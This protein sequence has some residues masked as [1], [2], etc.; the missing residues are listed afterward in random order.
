MPY[1]NFR[2]WI[3]NLKISEETNQVFFMNFK[4]SKNNQ[5]NKLYVNKKFIRNP[6]KLTGKYTHRNPKWKRN[7]PYFPHICPPPLTSENMRR[8]FNLSVS[9]IYYNLVFISLFE[10]K[11]KN[12]HLTASYRILFHI[13]CRNF[14]KW[15]RVCQKK[16]DMQ[17]VNESL[18]NIVWY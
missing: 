15:S 11:S 18:W 16:R 13:F 10:W 1:K 17:S 2:L 14:L 7:F 3:M 12:K 9:K 8:I 4:N 5:K 6:D